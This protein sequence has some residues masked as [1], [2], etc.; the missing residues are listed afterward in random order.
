[1]HDKKNLLCLKTAQQNKQSQSNID[2]QHSIAKREYTVGKCLLSHANVDNCLR[3][4]KRSDEVLAARGFLGQVARPST[5]QSNRLHTV[6]AVVPTSAL[7][8]KR[9]PKVGVKVHFDKY[10]AK[11]ASLHESKLR[12]PLQPTRSARGPDAFEFGTLCELIE[13]RRRYG[14]DTIRSAEKAYARAQSLYHKVYGELPIFVIGDGTPCDIDGEGIPVTY[15]N[16]ALGAADLR[17][18][19]DY[20]GCDY[21]D[22]E[23]SN[24]PHPI[25]TYRDGQ[26]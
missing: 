9:P 4:T 22:D 25:T 7:A 6:A 5:I 13:W 21:N 17:V 15:A 11:K 8:G 12:R 26:K 2:L 1:M 14:I 10:F 18:T 19:L 3:C 23:V 20:S 24:C 16:G